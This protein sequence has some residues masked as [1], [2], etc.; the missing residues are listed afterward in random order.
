MS[1]TS[2]CGC[3]RFTLLWKREDFLPRADDPH[4]IQEQL[5][6]IHAFALRPVT[7]AQQLLHHV[8]QLLQPALLGVQLLE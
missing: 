2:G 1:S 5:I 3:F 6:F 4:G 7:P 8:L